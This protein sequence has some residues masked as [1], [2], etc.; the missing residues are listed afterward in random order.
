M[1]PKEYLN[2][3]YWAERDIRLK[4]EEIA[5][6]E[7][8][9]YNITANYSSDGSSASGNVRNQKEILSCKLVDYKTELEKEIDKLT[10]LKE[11]IKQSISS[12]DNKAFREIL[13]RRYI[14]YQKWSIISERMNYSIRHIRRLHDDALT[15]IRCP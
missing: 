7:T 13:T 15:K 14:L 11:E 2:Q 12:V 8:T 1:S 3:A 9:L 5:M 10:E 4:E 6:M